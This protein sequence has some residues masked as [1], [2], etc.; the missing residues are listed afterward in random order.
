LI[1]IP[2]VD[3]WKVAV[4]TCVLERAEGLLDLFVLLTL[5]L[6]IG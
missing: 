3:Q 1:P 2:K 6:A 5:H 4:A